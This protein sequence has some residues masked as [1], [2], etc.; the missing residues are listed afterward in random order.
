[1]EDSRQDSGLK[2]SVLLEEESGVGAVSKLDAYAA[3][4]S[5][6]FS[7]RMSIFCACAYLRSFANCSMPALVAGLQHLRLRPRPQPPVQ[8]YQGHE[9]GGL[10]PGNTALCAGLG[11]APRVASLPA[12]RFFVPRGPHGGAAKQGRSRLYRG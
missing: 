11:A 6:R 7:V 9:E 1:M 4:A 10:Q 3:S 12:G 2:R 8:D 5:V